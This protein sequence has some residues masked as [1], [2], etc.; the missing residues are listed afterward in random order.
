MTDATDTSSVD[1]GV[2]FQAS[3]TGR[4]A[5]I[6][7][8]KEPDNTGTHTGTLWT[9]SGTLLATGTFSNESAQRLAGAGLHHPGDDHR[10]DDLRGLVPH[11]RGSLRDH[12]ERAAPRR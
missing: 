1:L 2:Q 6:R 3:R 12:L 9:A 5:A 7:F 4:S 10:R 8:Y 11:Q